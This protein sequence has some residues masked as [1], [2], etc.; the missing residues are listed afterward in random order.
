M[1]QQRKV[2]KGSP[3]R[4][5]RQFNLSIRLKVSVDTARSL[6]PFVV[7]VCFCSNPSLCDQSEA[8]FLKQKQTK[9]TKG[10]TH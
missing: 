4:V 2:V 8:M 1:D 9:T 6:S 7:F 3:S 5:I 10:N